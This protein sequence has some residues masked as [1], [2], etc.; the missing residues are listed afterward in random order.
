MNNEY[1]EPGTGNIADAEHQYA[2]QLGRTRVVGQKQRRVDARPLVTGAPVYAAEFE[3][4]NMLHARILH[5]PHAHANIVSIDK[6]KAL[7]LPGVYAVLTHEDVPRVAHSTA[8]QPYP[9][10]SPYDAYLLDKRVRYVGD[11]V[12]FVA[13]ETPGIA[14]EALN[15]IDVTYEVLPAVFDPLEAMREG[16][17][18]LHE[19]DL[20]HPSS[21]KKFG[22]I[23]DAGHN[24]AA[25]EEIAH[26]DFAAA[27]QEAD[28]IVEG[29]YRVPYISHA[30]LEPHISTA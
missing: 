25:H 16:A 23:Y 26:G 5:S 17:P 30:V 15:L 28:I 22:D 11:W 27:M 14:E 13:A 20:T 21:G 29:E 4:P 18:Q 24:L 12:A 8:G 1:Y 19:P 7:A 10:P 3:Q 2:R 6:S 9:E